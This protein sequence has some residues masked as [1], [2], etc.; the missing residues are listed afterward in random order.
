[1]KKEEMVYGERGP[2]KTRKER[3]SHD[4]FAEAGEL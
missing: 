4:E 1:M 3:L 2:N